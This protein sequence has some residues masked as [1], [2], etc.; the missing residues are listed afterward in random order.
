MGRVTARRSVVRYDAD[1]R[2]QRHDSLAVEEPMEL[3]V[4]GQ[5]FSVTMRTP[6][7]DFELAQGFLLSEGVISRRDQ[8]GAIRYC[9]GKNDDDENTYNVL[10]VAVRGGN[11]AALDAMKRQTYTTSSCGICGKASLEAVVTTTSH[12]PAADATAFDRSVVASLPDRLRTAQK[13]FDLTGGLHAAGLFT[14][15][16]EPLV[17]REDVGR[18]NAVDK[19]LGWALEHDRL[20]LGGVALCVSGRASFEL[21]QKATMAGVPLLVAVSAPSSL[22]VSLAEEVGLTIAGFVR[23]TSMNVYAHPERITG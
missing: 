11:L 2:S 4:N 19:V 9:A 17:I 10:D 20:P 16:G 14:A 23:G 7:S 12:S 5:Q 3:R 13:V 6:G 22:A 15:D 8:I 21:A 18:H 1:T